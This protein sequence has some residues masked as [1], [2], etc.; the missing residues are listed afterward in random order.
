MLLRDMLN[1]GFEIITVGVY[2]EGFDQT[3]LDRKLTPETL[4][5]L[6]K[7][8][9]KYRINPSGEGGEFETL[10]LDGPIFK[11]KLVIDES[12]TRW[13]KDSGAMFVEK[14][15]LEDKK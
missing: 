5:E 10:V 1:A 11:K 8:C 4:E 7:L 6:L 14:A 2:A 13:E 15:H 9:E 12:S 3:W